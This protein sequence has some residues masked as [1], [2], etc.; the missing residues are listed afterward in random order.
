[1]AQVDLSVI[2][3][4]FGRAALVRRAVESVLAQGIRLEV[5]LVD[6]GSRPPIRVDACDERVRVVR[7]EQNGGAAAA[8]N[9][10]VAE[11]QARWLA[12]LDSDDV[13]PVNSLLPRFEMARG[14]GETERIIFVGGFADVWPATNRTRVRVPKSSNDPLDFAAGCWTC[15]GSTALLSRQAWDYSG[16]Q[17]AALRRLEDYEWLLRWSVA[18]GRVHT[19]NQ[20]VAEITRGG[21]APPSAIVSAQAHILSKHSGLP[22]SLKR[23]ME[24]YLALELAASDLY[25]GAPIRGLLALARSWLLHPRRQLVLERYWE[26]GMQHKRTDKVRSL[27]R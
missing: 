27:R 12:F 9:A 25:H 1:M 4:T 11:S 3:P 18:G 2:V 23:R 5:I 6:D 8:R 7:L 26:S 21:K 22:P 10:G 19:C 13:W 16:G 14:I 17:D 15:P 20:V 24:S